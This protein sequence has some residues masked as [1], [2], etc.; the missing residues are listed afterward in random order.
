MY[1]LNMLLNICLLPP[2]PT[3]KWKKTKEKPEPAQ[4]EN[5]LSPAT[6]ARSHALIPRFGR[7]APRSNPLEFGRFQVGPA[8]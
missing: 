8:D 7:F 3:E 1:L 5:Y 4:I 6:T 2:P